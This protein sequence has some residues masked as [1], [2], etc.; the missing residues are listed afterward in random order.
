VI[1]LKIF[2]VDNFLYG[3]TYSHHPAH[4]HNFFCVKCQQ[5]NFTIPE[6]GLISYK[7]SP[8]VDVPGEFLCNKCGWSSRHRFYLQ[9]IEDEI[10][11]TN[12]K[13]I[14][15]PNDDEINTLF[16]RLQL[17][18]LLPKIYTSFYDDKYANHNK[19]QVLNY[20]NISKE[21]LTT[22]TY[23]DNFFDFV[24]SNHT[25]EHI[26]NYQLALK[27]LFRIT[28]INGHLII[29]LPIKW[30]FEKNL[31]I[32]T[33]IDDKI[34]W[35]S[36][37]CY[38]GEKEQFPVFWEF[39][40]EFVR[41]LHRLLPRAKITIENYVDDSIGLYNQGVYIIRIIKSNLET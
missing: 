27:E 1:P 18:N 16:K 20:I 25:L 5:N 32:A 36:K 31:R 28:K 9:F 40:F 11:K 35:F 34:H 13:I 41:D 2:T 29:H 39:G 14:Y 26:E 21:D 17:N 8:S 38:H 12:F 3:Y 22:I 30:N 19:D 37:P 10:R 15:L 33:L 7:Q 4:S 24:I 23:E 6:S